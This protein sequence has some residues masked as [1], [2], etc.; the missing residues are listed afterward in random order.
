MVVDSQIVYARA[1]VSIPQSPRDSLSLMYSPL[2]KLIGTH[3]V[4]AHA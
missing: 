4:L 3:K 2:R 1:P